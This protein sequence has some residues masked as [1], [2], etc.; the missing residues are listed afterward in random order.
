MWGSD[1]FPTNLQ[2]VNL[3]PTWQVGKWELVM[4]AT[5]S[6]ASSQSVCADRIPWLPS[7]TPPDSARS[8]ISVSILN[9]LLV[10]EGGREGEAEAEIEQKNRRKKRRRKGRRKKREDSSPSA[11]PTHTGSVSHMG[12]GSPMTESCYLPGFTL[13]ASWNGELKLTNELRHSGVAGRG[14]TAWWNACPDYFCF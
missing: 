13:R 1:Q 12:G 14:M 10:W 8:V 2:N 7:L 11:S 6:T 3:P 5:C 4:K 9:S